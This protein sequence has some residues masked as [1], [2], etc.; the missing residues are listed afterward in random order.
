MCNQL[1]MICIKVFCETELNQPRRESNPQPQDEKS[2]A[3]I[4]LLLTPDSERLRGR[5]KES[6]T[7]RFNILRNVCAKYIHNK[8]D[9]T[10]TEHKRNVLIEISIVYYS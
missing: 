10:Y 1:C 2:P 8:N 3:G 4:Y 6:R 7:L 5:S 9:V